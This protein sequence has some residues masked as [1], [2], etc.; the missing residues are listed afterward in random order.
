MGYRETF[1]RNTP[2]INGR[3]QCV[4]CK[5]WFTKDQ[6]DV[7]HI[8]AKRL[9]GTDELYNLQ[10]MCKHCNRSKGKNTTGAEVA[11]SVIMAGLTGAV[12]G[13]LEGGLNNLAGLGKSVATRKVKDALGIKYKR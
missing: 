11:Q 8:I 2:S 4:R 5:G 7:D 12:N 13:G 10:P 9:G 3:Y 6:I 1:F